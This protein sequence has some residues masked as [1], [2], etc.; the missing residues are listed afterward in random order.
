MAELH[1]FPFFAKDW[2]SSDARL[3]MTPEQ[4]GAYIDLLAVAWAEGDVEPSLSCD[5]SIL[6]TQSGLA[7]RWRVIGPLIRA[8]FSERNSRLYNAKLSEV[9]TASQANHEKAVERGKKSAKARSAKRETVSKQS[10][11]SGQQLQSEEAVVTSPNGLVLPASAPGGALGDETPRAPALPDFRRMAMIVDT[12]RSRTTDG[13]V[14]W[15]RMQRDSGLAP[16]SELYRYAAQ[17]VD[18]PGQRGES[19]A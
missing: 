10:Q 19:A 11:D 4:R 18:E 6:A 12:R 7:K 2:L 14:W 13:D 16:G 9:W 15:A 8:Q 3:S 17:H 5:D 1:W